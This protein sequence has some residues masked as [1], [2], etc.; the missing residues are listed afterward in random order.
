MQ[1]LQEELDDINIEEKGTNDV[2]IHAK[3]VFSTTNNQLGIIDKVESVQDDGKDTIASN[4]HL[5]PSWGGPPEN[6]HATKST[7]RP[8]ENEEKSSHP[9]E[10]S[11]SGAGIDSQGKSD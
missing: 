1:Q 9:G 3:L 6:E 7:E 8:A 10:I 5:E 11:L 4:G 2:V